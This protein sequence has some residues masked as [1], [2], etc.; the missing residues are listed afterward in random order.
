MVQIILL[1]AQNKDRVKTIYS[2]T[3]EMQKVKI[4]A[5][6]KKNVATRSLNLT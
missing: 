5:K 1:L 6:F 4:F 3:I 2:S